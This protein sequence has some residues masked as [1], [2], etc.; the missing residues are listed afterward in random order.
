M[1]KILW[2]IV[3]S[4]ITFPLLG[5]K[6]TNLKQKDY[7]KQEQKIISKPK[8]TTKIYI[9]DT[10][11]HC[12]KVVNKP[13]TYVINNKNNCKL[14]TLKH[15]NVNNNYKL[16]EQP[17]PKPEYL[18]NFKGH[19]SA[20]GAMNITD[21]NISR[22]K[23]EYERDTKTQHLTYGTTLNLY[24]LKYYYHGYKA[25]LFLRYYLIANTSGEGCFLQVRAG[26]GKLVNNV[27]NTRFSTKGAGVDLGYKIIIGKSN[28]PYNVSDYRYVITLTPMAGVNFYNDPTGQI[29]ISWIWQLRFGYQF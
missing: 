5:Q 21:L 10:V 23:F 26:Y 9:I 29:P 24:T 25:E 15:V 20:S 12:K 13:K 22:L 11:D 19:I 14:D 16:K 28:N 2:L 27:D 3:L 7:F 8:D 1:R 6:Q 18:F 4:L 17:K